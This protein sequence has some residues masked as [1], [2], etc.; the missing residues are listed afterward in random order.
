MNVST[1]INIPSIQPNY[2][3]LSEWRDDMKDRPSVEYGYI[4]NYLILNRASDGKQILK[5]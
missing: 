5:L 3:K 2:V 4:Y 1:N